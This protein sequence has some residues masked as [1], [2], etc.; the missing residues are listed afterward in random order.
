MWQIIEVI[1]SN[2]ALGNSAIQSIKLRTGFRVVSFRT[3]NPTRLKWDERWGQGCQGIVV[4]SSNFLENLD[5][6]NIVF[7]SCQA[8]P[9]TCE[10][11]R[12]GV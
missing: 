5:P 4:L 8:A 3:R 11:T 7:V 10:G 2:P 6:E 1:G 12:H 9:M